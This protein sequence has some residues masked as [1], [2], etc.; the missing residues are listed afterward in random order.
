LNKGPSICESPV[1]FP[2]YPCFDN[3]RAPA[4]VV[5]SGSPHT[6]CAR[7][8]V[9]LG[10]IE[11]HH[12]YFVSPA[13]HLTTPLPLSRATASTWTCGVPYACRESLWRP[14]NYANT[15][16]RPT[17]EGK[18]DPPWPFSLLHGDV[19]TKL[20]VRFALVWYCIFGAGLLCCWTL[21][22]ASLSSHPCF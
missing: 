11:V 21:L 8:M 7:L 6:P 1:K 2:S 3:A 9:A 10:P 13:H 14:T 18:R 19:L 16:F 4:G 15:P 5:E 22:R 17:S 12:S 20:L